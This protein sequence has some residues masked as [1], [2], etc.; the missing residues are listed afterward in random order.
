MYK[1]VDTWAAAHP[2]TLHFFND[3]NENGIPWSIFSGLSAHFL[4]GRPTADT[5]LII[6][7]GNDRLEQVANLLPGSN[8][9]RKLVKIEASD[10]TTLEYVTDELTSML[11]ET[12]VQ[13]MQPVTPI[14]SGDLRYQVSLT[15]LAADHRRKYTVQG[16]EVYVAHPFDSLAL[17]SILQRGTEQGKHDFTDSVVLARHCDPMSSYPMLRAHEIGLDDRTASF[18]QAC[19]AAALLAASNEYVLVA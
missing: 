4:Y 10:G 2:Q 9:V 12:E 14:T 18:M 16:A 6:P 8:M 17:K 3:L 15:P 5:D 19:G 7:Q 13:I 1:R 11:D